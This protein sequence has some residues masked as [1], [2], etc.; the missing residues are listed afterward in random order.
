MNS[1]FEFNSKTKVNKDTYL[2]DVDIYINGDTMYI[3]N[4]FADFLTEGELNNTYAWSKHGVDFNYGMGYCKLTLRKTNRNIKG[5]HYSWYISG[6]SGDY[7]LDE[8]RRSFRIDKR[9]RYKLH[10]KVLSL[11]SKSPIGSRR[12]KL[13]NIIKII[14]HA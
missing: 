6:R 8:E 1:V 5:N 14:E 2:C 7:D 11:Y 13:K 9:V 12:L 4:R 3:S 10:K